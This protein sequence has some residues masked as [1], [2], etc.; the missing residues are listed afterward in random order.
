MATKYHIFYKAYGVFQNI[1]TWRII[2]KLRKVILVPRAYFL[3]Q[4]I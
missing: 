1:K 4:S 3:W 2:L